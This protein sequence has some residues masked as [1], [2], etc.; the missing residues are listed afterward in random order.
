MKKILIGLAVVVVV[1]GVGAYFLFANLGAVLK[2]AIEK[3]GSD[4]TQASVK[5]ERIDLSA[6][7][8]EGKIVGLSV[9]NPKGF[10]TPQAFGLGE[11]AL[12]LD[13]ASL[14]SDVVTIK[15]IVVAAPKITYEHASGGSNLDTLKANVQRFAEA[16][17]AGGSKA[18]AEKKDKAESKEK[19]LIIE[20][21]SVRDGEIA[22]SHAALQGKALTAKLPGLELRDI[23]KSKGGATPAEVADEVIGKIS[24]AANKAATADIEKTVGRV[25]EAV[26]EGA[27]NVKDAAGNLLRGVMGGAQ[28]QKQ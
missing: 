19:K 23:G 20:R 21:L 11:V 9:G 18:G 1:V 25:V 2:A 15:E 14:K 26:K 7:S 3:V 6:T 16:H 17:G 5:V 12:K 24:E 8:G 13:V 27:Q 28:Q 10:K 4:A 22:V